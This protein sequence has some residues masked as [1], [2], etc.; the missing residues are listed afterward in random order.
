MTDF[1]RLF[2]CPCCG[3]GGLE[4][5]RIKSSPPTVAVACSECDRTWVAPNKVGAND[6]TE[7]AVLLSQLG[8]TESWAN[9]ECIH[10]GIPW[11]SLDADYHSILLQRE[12]LRNPM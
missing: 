2:D 4:L 11:D 9:L 5:V 1:P 12:D 8:L 10:Q 6:E 7:L 3:Q